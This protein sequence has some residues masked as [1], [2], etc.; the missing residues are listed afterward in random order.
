MTV[1]LYDYPGSNNTYKVKL[2]L[3]ALNISWTTTWVDIF[4]RHDRMIPEIIYDNET[5]DSSE[6][7]FTFANDNLLQNT[8][9]WK[10]D[11]EKLKHLLYSKVGE[12]RTLDGLSN[13][14]IQSFR[15]II[16][17]SPREALLWD[18]YK[19]SSTKSSRLQARVGLLLSRVV[20]KNSMKKLLLSLSGKTLD[21]I[22][23]YMCILISN[24]TF[25]ELAQSSKV[26]TGDIFLWGSLSILERKLYRKLFL[27]GVAS[28]K[29][30]YSIAEHQCNDKEARKFLN[31]WV[32]KMIE[33]QK[34]YNMHWQSGKEDDEDFKTDDR[35]TLDILPEDLSVYDENTR[36][37]DL[38]EMSKLKM[39]L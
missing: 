11:S 12:D 7:F 14:G 24:E 22:K 4:E 34:P 38:K 18:Y 31:Q 5:F 9:V 23:R 6:K 29:N 26:N 37:N 20:P 15:G 27:P 36:K 13:K 17:Y 25:Q 19:T 30:V 33:W 1:N 2:L 21:E 10:M 3:T 39:R 32:D 16:E 8:D 28:N 35:G